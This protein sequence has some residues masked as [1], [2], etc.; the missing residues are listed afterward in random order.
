MAQRNKRWT[1][2]AGWQGKQ[3]GAKYQLTGTAYIIH[4]CGHPTALWPYYGHTPAGKMII[5]PN[6]R[7]FAH[8]ADAQAAMEKLADAD[9]A[10]FAAA[11]VPTPAEQLAEAKSKRA[12]PAA[13]GKKSQ[14]FLFN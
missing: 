4:H 12:K 3:C 8:L 2:F 13:A 10:A 5:A 14:G 7:A 1:R 6:G 9:P 11:V